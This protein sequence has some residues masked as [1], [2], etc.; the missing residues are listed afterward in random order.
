M[1]SRNGS[2]LA[3]LVLVPFFAFS[4]WVSMHHGPLGFVDT[5]LRGGWETQIFLDLVIAM[6]VASTVVRRDA[7]QRGI[8]PWPWM[9][10]MATLGSIGLLGYFVYRE[11][12]G[13]SRAPAA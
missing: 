9:V 13:V 10:A 12:P 11:L 4:V 1:R 7:L 2:L 3:L 6:A 8:A 5:A